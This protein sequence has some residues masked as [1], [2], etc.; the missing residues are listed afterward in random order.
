MSGND[1]Y[2]RMSDGELCEYLSSVESE[3]GIRVRVSLNPLAKRSGK[4]SHAVVAT[5]YHP[6]GKRV[7]E[8]ESTQ[9]L[10]PGGTS[11]TFTGAAF[12]VAT[13]LV[14]AVDEWAH[15]KRRE[16]EVWEPGRLTPLEQYIANSFES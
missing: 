9:C 1:R 8:L 6:T 5:A 7:L 4:S 13:Q 3:Y 10:F 16:E 15:R 12:Y 2:S 11:K 14:Q